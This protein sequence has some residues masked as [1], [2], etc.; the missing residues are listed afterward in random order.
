MGGSLGRMGMDRGTVGPH[1]KD[2][3]RGGL[4]DRVIVG[5]WSVDARVACPASQPRLPYR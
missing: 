2:D 3:A 1:S 5:I 4:G